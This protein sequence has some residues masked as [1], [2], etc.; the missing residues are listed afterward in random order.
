MQQDKKDKTISAI[1]TLVIMLFCI[2]LCSWLGFKLPNPPIE[3][4][5]MGVAGEVLGEIEGFGNNDQATFDDNSATAS[6]SSNTP[7]DSYTTGAEPT[8]VAKTTKTE[9]KPK[10]TTNPETT[11]P[12]PNPNPATT[13]TPQPTTNPNATFRGRRNGNGGEGKGTATGSGQAGSP[14]G[15]Q[16]AQGGSGKG[17]GAGFSLGGRSLRG[18]LPVPVYTS[19]KDGDVTVRIKVDRNGNVIDAEF[20]PK[21]SKNYDQSMVNA[22]IE[23]ARKAHFNADPNATEYQYGTVTYKFRRQG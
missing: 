1:S 6:P 22:A 13:E 23:A 7:D 18:T 8:P 20:T 15:T 16:G 17:N 5:G 12:N 3:E 10:P 11:K 21:G 9:E 19:S 14:D 4:E 2:L